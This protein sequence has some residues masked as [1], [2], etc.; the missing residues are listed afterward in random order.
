MHTRPWPALT[1][2][3]LCLAVLLGP[4]AGAHEAPSVVTARPHSLTLHL[5][6]Y[7]RVVPVALARLRAAAAGLVQGLA[8]EPGQRVKAGVVLGHLHGPPVAALLA[9]RRAAV[10][11]ARAGLRSARRTLVSERQKRAARLATGQAVAR[12]QASVAQARA[13]LSA[14]R[15]A[16]AAARSDMLLRAP[17]SGRVASVAVADGERVSTGEAL[18]TLE[19]RHHLWLRAVYYGRDA[20]AVRVGMQGRFL[21]AGGAPP[22]RVR[23]TGLLPAVQPAGGQPVALRAVG[24]VPHWSSGQAGMVVL[25]GGRR[26]AVAV[27]TRALVLY[28]GHWW[29]LVRTAHGERRR[30]VRPGPAR[31][32]ETLIEQ[33]LSPGTKVV[34]G[35]AYLRF[36]RDVSQRYTPPD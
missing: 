33:G 22:V 8:V 35:N 24:G 29:V 6:A 11:E 36:H 15:A 30:A 28:D 23:V 4:C 31:G 27:P 26:S 7:G 1:A 16:L 13:R 10:D 19:P 2:C 21:P 9:R 32:E 14:A 5:R 3:T 25:D 20:R 12:A 17:A 18:V 34:V